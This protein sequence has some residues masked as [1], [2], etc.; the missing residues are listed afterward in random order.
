L[1][2]WR[3]LRASCLRWRPRTRWRGASPNRGASSTRSACR[4]AA[5]RTSPRCCRVPEASLSSE[6][7]TA[8]IAE[9]FAASGKRAA[10]MPYLM[11]GY[12]TLAESPQIGQACAQAG[13]ALLELGVP[14]ADP[15]ADGPVIHA[16]GT[17]A[18]QAGADMAGA[19][20]GAP[21][22]RRRGGGGG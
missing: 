2:R 12:P 17:K 16:A 20:G 18:L 21:Q 6:T 5:T 13:A 11:A 3:G 1:A 19:G 10:L 8:R 4:A 14:Y 9:A 7:G 15:L 22:R